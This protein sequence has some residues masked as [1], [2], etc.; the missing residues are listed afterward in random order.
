M[1][2]SERVELYSVTPMNYIQI[3][4]VPPWAIAL[5]KSI[6]FNYYWILLGDFQTYCTLFGPTLLTLRFNPWFGPTDQ[7][8]VRP[9]ELISVQIKPNRRSVSVQTLCWKNC[10]SSGKAVFYV[11]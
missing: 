2:V 5:S 4:G 11:N 7:N 9:K 1:S 10:I 6:Q 8:F 3:L